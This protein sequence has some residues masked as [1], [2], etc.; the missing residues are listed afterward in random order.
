MTRSIIIIIM[1][2]I[3]SM[4][5]A[6][7]A[8]KAE[9]NSFATDSLKYENKTKTAEVTIAADWPQT[10]NAPLVNAIREYVSEQLGGI[11]KGTL[12]N[13]DSAIQFYGEQQMARM[14]SFAKDLAGSAASATYLLQEIKVLAE[15]ETFVTYTDFSESYLGG[16]HGISSMSGTTFRK[17]DGRRFGR[18]MLRNTDTEAFRKLLKDGLKQY[19][20]SASNEPVDDGQLSQLLLTNNSVDYLP[21]PQATPYLTKGGVAFVYQPY[22][23]APYAAG[24]PSFTIPYEKIKPFLIETILRM[25]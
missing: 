25:I 1:A 12:A 9:Q 5:A 20:S 22:E 3:V 16:A 4:V 24:R 23:I 13:G 19:F 14:E 11:Y 15:T 8:N 18:E 2:S 7:G 10:G 17:S 6:C 21:L